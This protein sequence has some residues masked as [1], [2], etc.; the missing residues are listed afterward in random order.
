H[1]GFQPLFGSNAKLGREVQSVLKPGQWD[2]LVQR[3]GQI[4]NP[5]VPTHPSKYAIPVP[6]RGQK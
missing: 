1:V 5:T 6:K 2:N 4:Q 3:L